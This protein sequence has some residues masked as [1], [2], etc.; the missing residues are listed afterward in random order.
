VIDATGVSL[1]RFF[2]HGID[3]ETRAAI[4]ELPRGRGPL[5][6]LIREAHPLRRRAHGPR[7]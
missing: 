7:P 5:G 4:G 3:A 2:T 1:E 6:V